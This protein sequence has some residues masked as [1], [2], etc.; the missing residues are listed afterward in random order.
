MNVEECPTTPANSPT[1]LGVLASAAAAVAGLRPVGAKGGAGSCKP[2]TV[3]LE[4]APS[5]TALRASFVT[6]EDLYNLILQLRADI[7]EIQSL[8]LE[9]ED[10]ESST[11][12]P[13]HLWPASTL[14]RS[15]TGSGYK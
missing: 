9:G 10:E 11:P 5:S 1:N 7:Q 8:L 2:H 15:R 3:T 6:L 13:E 14:S 12:L 4:H